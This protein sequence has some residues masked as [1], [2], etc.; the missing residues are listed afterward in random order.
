[1]QKEIE[2]ISRL[3][4]AASG[5]K[6]IE[7]LICNVK[8]LSVTTGEWLLGNIAIDDGMIVGVG[9]EEYEAEEF[10][11]KVSPDA[12][13][14]VSE[15]NMVVINPNGGIWCPLSR[16]YSA[17]RV[18]VKLALPYPSEIAWNKSTAILLPW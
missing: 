8:Y 12:T 13:L 9:N 1:M 7:L 18:H 3:I 2:K 4:D 15:L 17:T 14:E 11:I 16:R 6:K 10:Y 5:N